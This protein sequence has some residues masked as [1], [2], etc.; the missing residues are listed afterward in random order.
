MEITKTNEM[1]L[2]KELNTLLRKMDDLQ[3]Q[4]RAAR[5]FMD[6]SENEEYR[7]AVREVEATS[8]RIGEIKEILSTADVLDADDNG[9]RIGIDSYISLRNRT[10][11]GDIRYF[12]IDTIGNTIPTDGSIPS[13]SINSP[14]GKKIYNGTSGVY[15]VSTNAGIIEYEIE[16]L[17]LVQI[18]ELGLI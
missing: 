16:K 13:L 15:K 11:G 14:V 7:A 10:T 5:E 8:R 9:P 3:E 1:R 12:R 2:R 18:Q 4:Q 6:L 17:S